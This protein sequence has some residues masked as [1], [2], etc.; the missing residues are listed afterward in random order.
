MNFGVEPAEKV[1][2]KSVTRKTPSAFD[3]QATIAER[4]TISVPSMRTLFQLAGTFST[5]SLANQRAEQQLSNARK[6]Y[7]ETY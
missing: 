1:K 6:R 5:D 3:V 2:V 4:G 7:D